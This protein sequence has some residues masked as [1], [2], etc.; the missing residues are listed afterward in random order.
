MEKIKV[1]IKSILVPLIIGGVVSFTTSA[2]VDYSTLQKPIL[3][4]PGSIFGVVWTILY[5]L[6]GI[7]YGMLK[8]K[9]LTNEEIDKIYYLQL[10][11][12]ALWSIIFFTLK[13]RFFAFIWIIILAILII[14]M[15]KKFYKKDKTSAFLQIPYL[16]W[17]IFASYL[18]LG[19]YILNK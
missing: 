6:M 16:L 5:I 9:N 4:P 12:N 7:S 15:I 19:T 3:S 8:I 17:V 18:N 1:Y 14:D 10:A 2:M 13:W 11:V